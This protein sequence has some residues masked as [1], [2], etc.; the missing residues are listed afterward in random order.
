MKNNRIKN[1]MRFYLLTSRLNDLIRQGQITWKISKERL[2]SVN[3]HIIQTIMLAIAIDSEFP[4]TKI[5]INKAVMMIALHEIE[6]IV[7][8]DITIFDNVS[9]K[10]KL[11]EGRKAVEYVFGDMLKKAEYTKLIAEFNERKTKESIFVHLCDKLQNDI[12]FKV[13]EDNGYTDIDN[14]ELKELLCKKEINKLVSARAE[15]IADIF[16]EYDRYR[17]KDTI[18]EKILDYVK[19]TDTKEID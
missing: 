12:Q 18:F 14:P 6:E 4:E 16:I 10:K 19:N 2:E 13:Y 5:N 3:E 15:T 1:I 17:Y 11:K 8:G 9:E 7:I